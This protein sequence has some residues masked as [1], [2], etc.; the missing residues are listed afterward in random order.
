MRS[1]S[2]DE[3]AATLNP[4]TTHVEMFGPSLHIETLDNAFG[5]PGTLLWRA[6]VDL[7]HLDSRM[8]DPDVRVGQ[9]HFVMARTGV[10]G[11]AVELLDRERF[12]GLRTDRFAPLF[13]DYRIGPELAQQ[14]SDTVEAVMFVLWI[15]IDPALRG[16]RLGAWALCQA[17]ETMM[18]TSNGLIL[19]HPH[20]DAEADAAPSVEQLESVERLNRYWMTTG[21]VPLRDRPQ[22]L[23]QHANRHALQ[24]AIEAYQQRFYGDDYT[25][26]IPL[27]PIRQRIADGG[28]FL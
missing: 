14:F 19:M 17:I 10:E 9:I 23:A 13:D 7:T 6:T 27:A 3:F 2:L 28:E 1:I 18:P 24:T 15:V 4:A 16:H 25:M 20:W 5:R 11:L 22:F 26:P 12:H 21:L 8:G